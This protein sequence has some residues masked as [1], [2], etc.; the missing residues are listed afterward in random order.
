MLNGLC[1]LL[2]DVWVIFGG[3]SDAL[4]KV[5]LIKHFNFGSKRQKILK[6]V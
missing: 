1:V 3:D 4:F 6:I 2:V 5:Q